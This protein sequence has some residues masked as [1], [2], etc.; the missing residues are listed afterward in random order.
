LSEPDPSTTQPYA[1]TL[2][3]KAVALDPESAEAH[4]QLGQLAL[5]GQRWKDAEAE[6]LLS[7]RYA[8]DRSKTHF[9]LSQLYRR[10]GQNEEADQQFEIYQSLKSQESGVAAVSSP[11]GKP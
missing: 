4:Y 10:T 6:F 5:Q 2:L 9:A 1:K 11:A 7:A 8:P 3:Q